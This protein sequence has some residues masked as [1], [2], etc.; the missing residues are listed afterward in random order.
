[1]DN[2][3]RRMNLQRDEKIFQAEENANIAQLHLWDAA[4]AVPC[5]K[6]FN[7]KMFIFLKK[8]YQINNQEIRGKGTK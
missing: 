3:Y 5:K 1:M 7:I 2:P 4:K 8:R 6:M